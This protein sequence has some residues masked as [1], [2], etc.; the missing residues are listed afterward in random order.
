[1]MELEMGKQFDYPNAPKYLTTEKCM[2]KDP[3]IKK[4]NYTIKA[5][6]KFILSRT[7]KLLQSSSK[8][9]RIISVVCK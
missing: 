6:D 7:R 8:Q 5:L 9:S 3:F 2:K 1:M 4:L